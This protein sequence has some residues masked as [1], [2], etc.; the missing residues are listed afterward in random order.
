MATSVILIFIHV[1]A[2]SLCFVLIAIGDKEWF[3][4]TTLRQRA[5]VYIIAVIPVLNL[6]L[7]AIMTSGFFVHKAVFGK[8]RKD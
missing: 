3:N 6:L 2:S 4:T 1:V 8:S 7:L 5:M